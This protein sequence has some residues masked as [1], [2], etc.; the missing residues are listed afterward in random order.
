[1]KTRTRLLPAAPLALAALLLGALSNP[2]PAQWADTAFNPAGA[3]AADD[4]LVLHDD[5]AQWQAFSALQ[6]RWSPV[7]AT[8]ATL[9]ARG[10]R[11][12][13]FHDGAGYRVWSALDGRVA[14]LAGPTGSFAGAAGDVALVVRDDGTGP[15]A[16]A[17]SA[18]SGDWVS[19]ALNAA[20]VANNEIALAEGVA[21]L[22]DGVRYVGFAARTATWAVL[23]TPT[24]Q[25][26][27]L[28][29]ARGEVA[30]APLRQ[31][32]G[33]GVD[34]VAAFTGVL[35]NWDVSGVLQFSSSTHIGRSVALVRVQH[36]I[37]TRFYASA[38]S[39][40]TGRWHTD[41]AHVHTPTVVVQW[42]GE[43]IVAIENLGF[44]FNLTTF[45]ARPGVWS[46]LSGARITVGVEGDTA[47]FEDPV[48]GSLAAASGLRAGFTQVPST[49]PHG[50]AFGSD[51]MALVLNADLNWRAYSPATGQW[52]APVGGVEFA[53][54]H[55]GA[56]LIDSAGRA[57]AFTP[58][59]NG[60]VEGPLL[61]P[62]STMLATGSILAWVD[63]V[64]SEL[65]L[66]DGRFGQVRPP[67]ATPP[68]ATVTSTDGVLAVAQA[69]DV[70]AFSARSGDWST[71][72]GGAL[73]TPFALPVAADGAVAWFADG[74]GRLW[75][76]GAGRDAELAHDWPDGPAF[77]APSPAT[78]A[79]TSM[80]LML[81]GA[82]A[83]FAFV[84][85]AASAEPT[86]L[87]LP[88]ILGLWH[89]PIGA[90][91][92]LLTV[93][94]G[95][96]GTVNAALPLPSSLP[97][98]TRVWIQAAFVDLQT[99]VLRFGAGPAD[100]WVF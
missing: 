7:A 59:W 79:G 45:A 44:A 73:T 69:G 46:V 4:F 94:L 54:A 15:V 31:L 67:I 6:R 87:A 85:L 35:G 92:P 29:F 88:P 95:P 17:F 23:D 100:A 43:S 42:G 27:D 52:S 48:T 64:S 81:S 61:A 68:G 37:L 38:F 9:V 14:T 36:P 3:I 40:Y 53:N 78:G 47:I 21:A 49:G 72:G 63:A 74:A 77:H 8:G 96:S 55:A 32:G 34:R 76:F 5:G 71:A 65:S 66:H 84:F 93:P 51:H 86:G 20:V 13:L 1:M 28:P 90:Q 75:A 33:G 80:R 16:H 25:A 2:A 57:R 89:L 50:L 24:G 41:F 12:A 62:G 97:G 26:G 99:E 19:I 56:G 11:V 91:I 70:M 39:A 58:R 60:W 98:A 82:P 83:E 18:L 10:A 30:L 22:R